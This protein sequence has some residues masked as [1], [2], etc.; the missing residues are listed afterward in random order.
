MH[1]CTGM[2][3][4][5]ALRNFS[6]EAPQH[7]GLPAAVGRGTEGRTEPEPQGPKLTL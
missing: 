4:S 7:P 1:A 5:Q 2:G 6:N 3:P